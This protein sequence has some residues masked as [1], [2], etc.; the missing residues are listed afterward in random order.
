MSESEEVSNERV[1]YFDNFKGI[2]I[3]FVVLGHF[4]YNLSF[5]NELFGTIIKVIYM[6]HMPAFAFI[7]GYFSKGEFGLKK[8]LKYFF[9]YF[10]MNTVLMFYSI[11][12][13]GGTV[14]IFTPYYSMWYL[15]SLIVWRI[16]IKYI[17]KVKGI[18]S[19]SIVIALLIGLCPEATNMFAISR[20]IAF[21]PFF[22]VGYKLSKDMMEKYFI[23]KDIKKVVLGVVLFV[24]AIVLAIGISPLINLDELTMNKYEAYKD[25]LNRFIIF[26]MAA[27]FIYS[28][29]LIVQNKKIIGLTR[30]GEKSL[31]IYIYHRIITL[32]ILKFYVA[33]KDIWMTLAL[34]IVLSLAICILLSLN[35]ISKLTD[36]IFEYIYMTVKEE[37]NSYAKKI[38]KFIVVYVLIVSIILSSLFY[39]KNENENIDNNDS[40]DKI[41]TLLSDKEKEDIDNSFSILFTGDLL[42]LKEQVKRGYNSE[43][44]SYNYDDVFEYT[45]KYISSAD[46]SIGVFEGPMAS[47]E[48]GYSNSDFDDGIQLYFNFPDEFGQAVKNAGFDLVTLAN[49]HMLDKGEEGLNR[50]LDVLDTLELSHTGGYRTEEE[51]NNIE[52]IEKDGLKIGI[53]SYTYGCNYYDENELIARKTIPLLVDRNSK[54]FENV[55][56][57]V[58]NDFIKLKAENPNVIIV[59]PHMGT[60]FSTEVDDFQKEWNEIFIEQGANIILGDHAHIVQP[61]EIKKNSSGEDV[62]IVNCP[63][64]F[65][66]SYTEYNGGGASIVEVYIDKVTGKL[67]GSS[68][69]PMWI[70]SPIE[71]NY[72][73]LPLYEMMNNEELKSKISVYELDKAEEICKFITKIMIN[74]E[75]KLDMIQDKLYFMANGYKRQKVETID[76]DTNNKIVEEISKAN[77]ICFIGDSI[78]EGSKNGGYGWYEPLIASFTNK[79]VMNVSK[80]GATIKTITSI[81]NE[82][83]EEAD[84][85]VIAIGTNDIRYRDENICAMDENEYMNEIDKLINCIQ[86]KDEAKFVFIAP[87]HSTDDDI[88]CKVNLSEKTIMFNRYSEKLKDFCIKNG[89]LFINPNDLIFEKLNHELTDKY[90]IDYIHPNVMSGIRLYSEAV[91]QASKVK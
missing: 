19:I 21:F 6:F 71:G 65:V 40:F 85:Y 42:L 26:F 25:I 86:N 41:Y 18:T 82:S 7:S 78:T 70:Q 35:F 45:K 62:I 57:S 76:I 58:E 38:I 9:Y 59:L 50:T 24:I 67:V 28:L 83:K 56:S 46:L 74:C 48:S 87:W 12:V 8:F 32:V 3:F 55:K 69:I 1:K 52:I 11:I 63:G 22:I 47:E 10:I 89:Y 23:E 51:R 84:L 81:Y 17:G 5:S 15:I 33:N 44:N 29:L 27:C 14:S 73:P 36:S 77:R 60:Q 37:K 72:R 88:L 20:T 43:T 53:L 80:G 54:N 4:L 75:L 79:T 2:L 66:N 64:N 91:M 68:I 13:E 90:L 61:I 39:D 30:F 16:S 34:L 31:Y 49:N